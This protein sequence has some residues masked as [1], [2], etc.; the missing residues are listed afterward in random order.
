MINESSATDAY[1]IS[2]VLSPHSKYTMLNSSPHNIGNT[3]KNA[4]NTATKN[5]KS[6]HRADIIPPRAM[7]KLIFFII[8]NY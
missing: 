1:D 3:Y 5:I 2:E 7:L 4:G 6:T 8:L